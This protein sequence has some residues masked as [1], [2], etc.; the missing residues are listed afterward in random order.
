[1][2]K[3]ITTKGTEFEQNYKDLVMIETAERGGLPTMLSSEELNEGF[4]NAEQDVRDKIGFD[5]NGEDI[6]V[7]PATDTQIIKPSEGKNAILKVTVNP[8]ELQNK[9]INP[10][11]ES[12]VVTSDEGYMGLSNVTVN[13]VDSTI[14]SN[15]Q[16]ENIKNDVT[17]LGVTGTLKTKL[18]FAPKVCGTIVTGNVTVDDVY[19]YLNQIDFT[20]FNDYKSLFETLRIIGNNKILDLSQIKPQNNS[21]QI[22]STAFAFCITGID[23]LILPSNVTLRQTTTSFG[24]FNGFSTFMNCTAEEIVNLDTWSYTEPTTR[25]QSPYGGYFASCFKGC[26]NLRKIKLNFRIPQ[27]KK[28]AYQEMFSGCTKLELLYIPG[29][30]TG[31][32]GNNQPSRFINNVPTTCAIVVNSTNE[33]SIWASNYP[34]YSYVYDYNT[35]IA[36]YH[37]HYNLGEGSLNDV[38]YYDLATPND[39]WTVYDSIVVTPPTGKRFVKWIDENGDD[40]PLTITTGTANTEYEVYAVYEDA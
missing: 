10:T 32:L 31:Y 27:P 7:N 9:T 14:D 23:K 30:G 37:I 34:D 26:T 16:A 39:T 21:Q 19:E 15:I 22:V 5:V 20:Q 35:W 2:K 12:Q 18:K 3:I 1:M 17:I 25:P 36:K 6:T 24:N 13:A 29:L 11:T 38:P 33:K 28:E 40:V 8:V 4:S